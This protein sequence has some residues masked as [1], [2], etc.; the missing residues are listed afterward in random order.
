[1]ERYKNQLER[2][3]KNDQNDNLKFEHVL[4]HDTKFIFRKMYD[5]I[6]P[7]LLLPHIP[8]T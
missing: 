4:I 8:R 5:L 3:K 2:V 7:K 1:M 6:R